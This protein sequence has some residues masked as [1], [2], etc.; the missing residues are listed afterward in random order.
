MFNA[1]DADVPDTADADPR[2]TRHPRFGRAV[3]GVSVVSIAGLVVASQTMWASAA[4]AGHHHGAGTAAAGSA[5]AGLVP[6]DGKTW[7]EG[8]ITDQ[9][10]HG[11]DNVNVEAW[12]RNPAA[13]APVASSLSYG[14]S[15][16]DPRFTHGGFLLEV[17]SDQAYRIVFSTVSGQEDGDPFRMKTY[18]HGRPIQ[19]RTATLATGRI[20]NLG[21]IALARQGHVASTTKAKLARAKVHPGKR[22]TLRVRVSSVFVSHVTGKITVHVAGKKASHRLTPR[23]HG[24][25]TFKL[26]RIH[27]PG[28]YKV[29]ATFTGTGTVHR[30]HAKPVKL[31]IR[32]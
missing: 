16:A 21:T 25:Q 15:A 22:A 17:P 14:V 20:R 5:A 2:R 23:S 4:P 19:V 7:I 13:T 3:V 1:K 29:H 26:P 11:Q 18:G 12:P 27:K 6:P 30:S 31:T 8:V 9:A 24:K 28:K 10:N 32:R